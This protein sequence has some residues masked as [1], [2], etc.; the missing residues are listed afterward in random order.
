MNG[1]DISQKLDSIL[2]EQKKLCTLVD[3]VEVS[4][5]NEVKKNTKSIT[6]NTKSIAQNT[7]S[8]KQLSREVRITNKIVK[9]HE[10]RITSLEDCQPSAVMA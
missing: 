1:S 10:E 4:V 7:K 9:N 5:L 2:D 3:K 6:Q 8:I